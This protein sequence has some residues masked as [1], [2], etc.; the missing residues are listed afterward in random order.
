MK[1]KKSFIKGALCGALA[2]LLIVGLV[3]CG[4]IRDS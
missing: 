3:S 1:D 2:G 4:S